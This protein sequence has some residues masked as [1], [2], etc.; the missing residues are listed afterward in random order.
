MAA[1]CFFQVK[2][3]R[4]LISGIFGLAMMLSFGSWMAGELIESTSFFNHETIEYIA[5][6]PM[7]EFGIFLIARFFWLRNIVLLEARV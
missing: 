4:T 5:S 6:I 1:Y 7:A 3:K 2:A